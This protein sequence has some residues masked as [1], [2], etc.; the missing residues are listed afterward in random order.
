MSVYNRIWEFE[1]AMGPQLGGAA[2]AH[3]VTSV[4][5]HLMSSE[6]VEPHNKW[7]ACAPRELLCEDVSRVA[8]T[9]PED[10]LPLKRQLEAEARLADVLV[11][12]LD[13][14]R[15][16]EAIAFEVVEVCL[17]AN[18]RLDVW[19]AKFSSLDEREVDKA[20]RTLGRPDQ[21]KSDAVA[22]RCERARPAPLCKTRGG[23][24]AL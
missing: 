12:W 16:G 24:L 6:F 20:W 15:E 18:R 8:W 3:A 1:K 14:D 9:V 11:L 2:F 4:T 23:A 5:G 19:R 22:A 7:H 21:N 17:N 13:C 10:K